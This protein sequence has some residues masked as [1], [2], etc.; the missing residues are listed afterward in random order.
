MLFSRE[1]QTLTTTQK[2]QEIQVE[3]YDEEEDDMYENSKF[4]SLRL[5]FV[6]KLGRLILFT[7]YKSKFV[8]IIN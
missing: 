5:F 2:D 8:H 1:Q 6:R 4:F 3:I 7:F